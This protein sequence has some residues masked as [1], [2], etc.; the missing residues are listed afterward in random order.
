LLEACSLPLVAFSMTRHFSTLRVKEV[1]R[2]TPE[3]VSVSFDIP[4]HLKEIFR[5]RQGQNITIRRLAGGEELRRSY[6]ICSSPLE[7]E[8]R[9]AVKEVAGGRFSG[10][11][12][13]QLQ[14][15]EELEVLPPSGKF[16]TELA[17]SLQKSYLAFAAGSGITPILSLIKTTLATEPQSHF[18]LVYGNRDRAS[19]IF[20]EALEAIKD[21]YIDRF[22]LHHV[23][24]RETMDTPLNQGRIDAK[25]CAELCGKLI[26]PQQ[27][28]EVFI[29]GPGD[30]TFTVRDWLEQNGVDRKKIHFELFHTREGSPQD[31]TAAGTVTTPKEGA[32]TRTSAI[33][34]TGDPRTGNPEK[35]CKVTIRQDGISLNFDLAYDGEAILDAA[36]RQGADLPYA[37]KGGVCCTCRARLLEGQVEMEVNY[38][39][40]ADE[41]AAGFILT[42]QS[43]PRTATVVI[44]FDEK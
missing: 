40:E 15:G 38:A 22:V 42:C 3:C 17:P 24:S 35:L 14:P 44:D 10:Y 8:L 11:A 30:M 4:D 34:T 41:L 13:Q 39:L 27:A 28:D 7:N 19:I 23:L 1:R 21:R 25:K 36:N 37:C 31:I 2:E 20:K 9:I 32:Q 18:T 5:Y 6:S 29:C 26:D 33:R 16:Y 43:H 12:N